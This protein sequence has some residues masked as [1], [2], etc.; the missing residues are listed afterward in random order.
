MLAFL[1][2]L[3]KLCNIALKYR[4]TDLPLQLQEVDAAVGGQHPS[5]VISFRKMAM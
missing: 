2:Q 1:S 4:T 3:G 5:C